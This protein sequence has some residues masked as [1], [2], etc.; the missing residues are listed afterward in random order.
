MD[1]ETYCGFAAAVVS[2]LA[3]GSF[4]VPIKCQAARKVPV[5]PLGTYFVFGVSLQFPQET[6]TRHDLSFA[7][8]MFLPL[9]LAGMHVS[10]PFQ[11]FKRT[12]L[13]FALPLVGSF[14]GLVSRSVLRRTALSVVCSWYPVVQPDTLGSG[15]LAWPFRKGFGRRSKFWLPLAG[16]SLCFTNRCVPR[17]ARPWR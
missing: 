11:S 15:T 12:R 17:R 4:A 6:T 5:D 9:V 1:T 10:I 8:T 13:V 2:I 14:Y 16:E 3:F 7:N